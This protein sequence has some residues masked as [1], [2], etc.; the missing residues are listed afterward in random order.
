MLI[1]RVFDICDIGVH[2]T[3]DLKPSLHCASIAAKAFQRCSL[4]LKG[5]QTLHISTLFQVFTSYVRP[6]LEYNTPVWNPWLIQNIK[7]VER[8]QR[9]F[10][11]AIFVQVK[12]PTMSYTDRLANLGLH[13]LEYRRVY[14][15]LVKC[16]KIVKNLVDLDASAFCFVSICHHT[17]Q[18][19][20]QS[21]LV[22]C[23]YLT[24]IFTQTFSQSELCTFGIHY[25]TLWLQHPPK[26]YLGLNSAMQTCLHF[27]NVT[28]FRTGSILVHIHL[29]HY[30][31]LCNVCNVCT[32]K[33]LL[34]LLL[35][36]FYY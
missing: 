24:I 4:L 7:C 27:V 16:F 26:Q 14:F 31:P 12:L 2:I 34:L 29:C 11:R 22:L 35:F 10:T 36:Y 25:Q 17:E 19:G 23:H 30:L 18:E 9:F 21:D 28:H 3:S 33:L 5:L 15:D 1:N 8:V 13:S 32:H 6:I 20:T